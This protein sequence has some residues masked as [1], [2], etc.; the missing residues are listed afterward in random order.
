LQ[1]D[2]LKALDAVLPAN[3]SHGNPVDII[4]D[5]P[6]PRYVDALQAL[7]AHPE[8]TG[9]ILFIQAPTAIVPS[10]DIADALVPVIQPTGGTPLPVISCWIGGPAVAEARKRFVGAG[11]ASFDMP[12]QAVQAIGMLQGYARNQAELAEAPPAI[13]VQGGAPPDTARVR[14]IVQ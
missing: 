14:E 11:I 1:P 7:A 5:A 9:T 10:S 13:Q 8:Q 4:G 3:W 12:E 2:L 6:A